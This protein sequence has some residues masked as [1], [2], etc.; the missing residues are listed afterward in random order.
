MWK[1]RTY[2]SHLWTI[3]A[4]SSHVWLIRWN[5]KG[6]QI[7]RTCDKF[8]GIC[9]TCENS[10]E[11]FS[12]V[13]NSHEF[14][15]G[16]TNTYAWRVTNSSQMSVCHVFIF[17]RSVHIPLKFRMWIPYPIPRI[18]SANLYVRQDMGPFSTCTT[19]LRGTFWPN[20][21]NICLAIFKV[22]R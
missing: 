16:V 21:K 5:L 2:L 19:R 14:Y 18:A 11:F 10:C 15:I 7:F 9:H 22:M 6:E 20:F 8:K 1:I 3:C 13:N 17:V 12:H 4:N